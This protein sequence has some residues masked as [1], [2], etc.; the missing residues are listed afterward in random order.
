MGG[1]HPFRCDL[2]AWLT[3]LVSQGNGPA[4]EKK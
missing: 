3:K 1:L 2:F 4:L